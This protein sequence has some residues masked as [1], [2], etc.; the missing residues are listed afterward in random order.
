MKK[1]IYNNI[2]P[3][4]RTSTGYAQGV[5]REALNPF[6]NTDEE[7]MSLGDRIKLATET[8]ADIGARVNPQFDD[9]DSNDLDILCSMRHDPL[10]IAE[11][12]GKMPESTPPPV[13]E[14]PVE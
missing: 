12:F 1:F 13:K 14:E 7:Y 4:T 2:S 5:A 8:G 10:D 3:R 11:E 9:K 6:N